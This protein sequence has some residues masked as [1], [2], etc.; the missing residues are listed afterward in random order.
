MIKIQQPKTLLRS[1]LSI[2]LVVILVLSSASL[3]LV[4][5]A[6]SI[7]QIESLE[8]HQEEIAAVYESARKHPILSQTR[9]LYLDEDLS[10]HKREQAIIALV[11]EYG[12]EQF[13]AL[14]G[15]DASVAACVEMM[16]LMSALNKSLAKIDDMSNDEQD[17][18]YVSSMRS[19]IH[20]MLQ[21]FALIQK[22]LHSDPIFEN[23]WRLWNLQK[24]EMAQAQIQQVA[25]GLQ[26]SLR[27]QQQAA[28]PGPVFP[29]W[30]STSIGVLCG[31]VLVG[32]I[33]NQASHTYKNYAE[34]R[35]YSEDRA[36]IVH[37]NYYLVKDANIT[38]PVNDVWVGDAHYSPTDKEGQNASFS[39]HSRGEDKILLIENTKE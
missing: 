21:D 5:N 11:K 14:P 19:G 8:A 38:G 22:V 17:D 26:Y 30:L 10:I 15:I 32:A 25:Q 27:M 33:V 7:D 35:A 18:Q 12:T 37:K 16:T 39:H 23:E 28:Y 3:S 36:F 9:A 31:G 13:A 20:F 4:A 29:Q 24:S 2:S 6:P 1:S 34:A